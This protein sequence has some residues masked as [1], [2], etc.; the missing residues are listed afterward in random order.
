[1]VLILLNENYQVLEFWYPLLRLKEAEYSVTVVS[2]E[3]KEYYSCE[4]YPAYPD[5]VISDID[6]EKFNLLLIP[7]TQNH[8]EVKAGDD[9][10]K[11]LNSFNKNENLIAVIGNGINTLI[12]ANIINKSDIDFQEN[13]INQSNSMFINKKII[14]AKNI[15]DLP[16]FMSLIL[17]NL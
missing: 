3:L 15:K 17:K 12:Q 14:Y 13:N 9:I 4:H 6:P 11:L 10:I 7:G 8:T 16:N 2:H 5:M 1:M